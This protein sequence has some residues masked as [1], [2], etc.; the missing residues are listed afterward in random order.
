MTGVRLDEPNACPGELI[1]G[2]SR[3]VSGVL[4]FDVLHAGEVLGREVLGPGSS[5][6]ELPVLVEDDNLVV[7]VLGGVVGVGVEIQ[8]LVAKLRVVDGA[9]DRSCALNEVTCH[10][11]ADAPADVHRDVLDLHP[12]D[13]IGLVVLVGL[14]PARGLIEPGDIGIVAS[15]LQGEAVV[16]ATLS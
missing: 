6:V 10:I 13:S 9:G 1:P 12:L 4:P 3:V 8:R 11:L 2:G 14:A 15:V 16:H 7:G 5:G